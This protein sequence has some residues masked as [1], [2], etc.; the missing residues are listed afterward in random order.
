VCTGVHIPTLVIS[1]SF[2]QFACGDD[3]LLLADKSAMVPISGALLRLRSEV[4][5][6]TTKTAITVFCFGV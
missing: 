3:D 5:E 2:H 1:P 4:R 6:T